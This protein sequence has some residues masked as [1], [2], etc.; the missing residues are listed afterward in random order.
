MC[1]RKC[2]TSRFV[3]GV[4]VRNGGV[5]S[6]FLLIIVHLQIA[7]PRQGALCA[8]AVATV[9]ASVRLLTRVHSQVLRHGALLACAVATVLASVWLLTSVHPQVLR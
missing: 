6:L 5:N 7:R 9:L 1:T 8:C 4:S 3:L 2:N